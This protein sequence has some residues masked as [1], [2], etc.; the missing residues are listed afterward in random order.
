ME[1]IMWVLVAAVAITA[2]YFVF[3]RKLLNKP[4]Q[5]TQPNTTPNQQS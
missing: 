3:V 1:P 4:A 2:I 5:P